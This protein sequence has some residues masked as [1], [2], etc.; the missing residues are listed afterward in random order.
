MR[1]RRHPRGDC[2]CDGNV[3]DECS[4]CGGDGIPPETATAMATN[5]THSVSAADLRGRRQ[6]KGICDSEDIPGCTIQIACNYNA[7]ATVDDGSCDFISCLALG[8]TDENACN[9]DPAALFEDGSCEYA[10]FPLDCDG[11]CVNDVDGDGVCDEFEIP[12]CVDETA[13]NYNAEATEDGD[14][15]VYAEE[16]FDCDGN[17]L[18][19]AN[20]NGLCDE[21]EVLGCTDFNACNF[22]PS[23]T[24]NDGSVQNWM[25]VASVGVLARYECGCADIPEAT[26]TATATSLTHSASAVATRGRRR[27][28]RHLR[29]RRPLRR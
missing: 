16:Y 25:L 9:Y 14:N 19:D 20:D 26:A 3:L 21:F 15:C 27:Q 18:N 24:Q 23:A 12:G 17:C 1:L 5:L 13:C 7:E 11:A 29:R 28:R 4:I 6:R 8:C 22:D 10:N 2:D